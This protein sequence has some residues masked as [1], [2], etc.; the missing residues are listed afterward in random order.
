M[1]FGVISMIICNISAP[2]IAYSEV[3]STNSG[4]V[5]LVQSDGSVE[6]SV[7]C[8]GIGYVV[9]YGTSNDGVIHKD[10]PANKVVIYD[11]RSDSIFTLGVAGYKVDF[12]S[13]GVK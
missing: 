9:N 2:D 1:L 10:W 12:S 5:T 7:V 8:N 3:C 6:V 4:E 11:R 13:K